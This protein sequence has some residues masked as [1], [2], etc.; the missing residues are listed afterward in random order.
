MKWSMRHHSPLG[1]AMSRL[2]RSIERMRVLDELEWHRWFAW[3]PVVVARDGGLAYWA[4][5]EFV[6]RQTGWSRSTGEWIRRYRPVQVPDGRDP[7]SKA[8]H[9]A[10][11]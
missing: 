5:L 9:Q 6:E 7:E 10:G 2:R 11:A 1:R 8:A 4:W 3:Y